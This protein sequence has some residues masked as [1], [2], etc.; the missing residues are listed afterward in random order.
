[1]KKKVVQF[2]QKSGIGQGSLHGRSQ[3]VQAGLDG[4]RNKLAAVSAEKTAAV[5]FAMW[6]GMLAHVLSLL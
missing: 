5:R 1:M 4:I 2:A 3:L 6:G